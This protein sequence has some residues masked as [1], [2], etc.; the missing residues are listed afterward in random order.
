MY[1]STDDVTVD[2]S[3]QFTELSDW[4]RGEDL[5]NRQLPPAEIQ[6]GLK[7]RW[8]AWLDIYHLFMQAGG[9]AALMTELATGEELEKAFADLA[10]GEESIL[11]TTLWPNLDPDENLGLDETKY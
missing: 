4:L 10:R 8:K 5:K 7:A 1:R 2:E 11:I 6:Y 9:N 3:P